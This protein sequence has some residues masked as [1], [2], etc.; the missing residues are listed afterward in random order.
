MIQL[1]IEKGVDINAK[2]RYY[3]NALQ[4]TSESGPENMIQLLIKK[5][6]D[7]IAMHCRRHHK[8][9]IKKIVQRL[10]EKGAD[11]NA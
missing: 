8:T 11:V 3:G 6:V 10:I 1:L 7:I 5:G 9:V 2:G 4:A